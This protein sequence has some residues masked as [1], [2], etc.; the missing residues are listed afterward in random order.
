MLFVALKKTFTLVKKFLIYL[1]WFRSYEEIKI[2]TTVCSKNIIP[3]TFNN[4][5]WTNGQTYG[6]GSNT[7]HSEIDPVESEKNIVSTLEYRV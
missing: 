6:D 3:E 4:L 1:N 7:L 5:L 2:S